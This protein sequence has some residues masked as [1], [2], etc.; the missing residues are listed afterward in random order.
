MAAIGSKG[1]LTLNAVALF[2]KVWL[3]NTDEIPPEKK[4]TANVAGRVRFERYKTALATIVGSG[5][6][7]LGVGEKG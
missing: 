2:V 1:D 6:H 7:L 3:C 5:E 4:D